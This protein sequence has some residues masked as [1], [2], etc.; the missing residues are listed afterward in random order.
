[1]KYQDYGYS[2][3]IFI[4]YYQTSFDVNEVRRQGR[5]MPIICVINI[6]S[7]IKNDYEYIF[8]DNKIPDAKKKK[9]KI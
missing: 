5:N 6:W 8:N 1:L 2:I 7:E 3:L 4:F 9:K